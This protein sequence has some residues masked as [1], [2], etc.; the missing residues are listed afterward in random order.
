[1]ILLQPLK[2]SLVG[3]MS[4]LELFECHIEPIAVHKFNTRLDIVL[5]VN[6]YH[7][8]C[9]VKTLFVVSRYLDLGFEF[10]SVR[11]IIERGI[12]NSESIAVSRTWS[13]I[14]CP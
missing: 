13:G 5:M 6:A 10:S 4:D 9:L 1:M 14:Y 7:Q 3:K 12:I 2:P 11:G 8:A